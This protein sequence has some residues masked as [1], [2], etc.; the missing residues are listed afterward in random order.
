M[1]FDLYQQNVDNNHYVDL[2]IEYPE[3][4]KNYENHIRESQI[5]QNS[6]TKRC[7]PLKKWMSH[8]KINFQPVIFL[9]WFVSLHRHQLFS[10]KMNLQQSLTHVSNLRHLQ[11][12]TRNKIKILFLK[13]VSSNQ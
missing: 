7:K 8:D 5:F 12:P 11:H 9:N 13:F 3:Q 2:K 10:M 4:K 1:V 6:K